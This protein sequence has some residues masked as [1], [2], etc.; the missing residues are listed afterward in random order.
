[1]SLI[2]SR[3]C[4]YALQAVLY[5]ALRPRGEMT[6]S[7][8]LTSRLQIPY[9]FL[10]KIL[11]DL[12]KKGLLKSLKG[13]TGG[14]ALGMQ[15]K[16][17]TLFHI[18]E[19]VDGVEFTTSCVLGFPECSGKNPCAVHEKWSALR[20]GM[21]NMLVSKNILELAKGMRKPEYRF[22]AR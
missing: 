6:S 9:H 17:I 21:Y 13:P 10:A 19:A 16:E 3:Q 14:F 1:M 8:E 2:F 15:A 22:T 11:Q 4:E 7:K 12:A 20:D 5:L 18:I